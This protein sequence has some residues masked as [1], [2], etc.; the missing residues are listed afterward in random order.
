MRRAARGC[1]RSDS[2]SSTELVSSRHSRATSCGAA[3]GC[4]RSICWASSVQVIDCCVVWFSVLVIRVSTMVAVTELE[5]TI[6][7]L[8]SERG[9]AADTNVQPGQ[10]INE[11][12]VNAEYV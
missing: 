11:K 12:I 4:S 6:R 8:S 5:L 2:R 9:D 1:S 7:Q 3:F 10:R